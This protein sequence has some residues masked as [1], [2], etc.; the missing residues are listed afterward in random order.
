MNYMY[1]NVVI[2][3][4]RKREKHL[5]Y[6]I[7]NTVPLLKKYIPNGKVIIVEQDNNNLFN[8]GCIL[9]IGIKEYE[10]KSKYYIT[11][12]IDLNP[13]ENTVLENYI[14]DVGNNTIQGIY[15]HQST[16]GG[17]IKFNY[18][19]FKK[20]NGFPNDIWG[21]GSEDNALQRRAELFSIKICKNYIQNISLGDNKFKIFNNIN[22]SN[23]INHKENLSK[24]SNNFIRLSKDEKIKLTMESGLNNLK[25]EIIE[26]IDLDKYVEIIKVKI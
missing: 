3:P 5:K 6:F 14:C 18:E 1:D 13:Y 17:I 2:I 19:T 9:N 4:Y 25:Y 12:D 23:K 21:W 22:D 24:Y 20:I 15:T 11:H 16:L 8:R 26:R 10:N 7:D